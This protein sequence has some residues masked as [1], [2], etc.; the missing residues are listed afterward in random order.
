MN[1]SQIAWIKAMIVFIND[2]PIGCESL[3]GYIETD[4]IHGDWEAFKQSIK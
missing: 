1:E 2:S 3:E 4:N